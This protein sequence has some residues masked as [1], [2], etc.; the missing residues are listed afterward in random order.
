MN[1]LSSLSVPARP[2]ER[3]IAIRSLFDVEHEE[4]PPDHRYRDVMHGDRAHEAVECPPV[5]MAVKHEVGTVVE[6]RAGEAVASQEGPDPGRLPF[7]GRRGGRVVEENDPDGAGGDG[8]EPLL[9]RLHLTRGL[10][11]DRAQAGLAEVREGR[12]GEAA[13]EALRPDHADL[14]PGAF[15]DRPA[16]VEHGD[17]GR[18]E[19]RDDLGC[20]VRVPVV[21]TENGD[22][23]DRE[24]AASVGQ[25]LGL[26]GLAVGRQVAG[27]KDGVRL[28]L[29]PREGCSNGTAVVVAT[30]KVARR[31]EPNGIQFVQSGQEGTRIE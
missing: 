9:D 19:H 14:R 26:L 27:Q 16:A 7:N 28:V 5:G 1:L 25:H 20:P 13:H 15:E 8:T 3:N 29:D 18:F 6:D 4:I 31:G 12:V 30:M 11:V 23:R 17:S 21:I 10:R 22:D 24:A 2:V